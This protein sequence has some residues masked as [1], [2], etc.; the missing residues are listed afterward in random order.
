MAAAAVLL[1][2][3][4]GVGSA[5]GHLLFIAAA[6][7][8][9]YVAM[10]GRGPLQALPIA[11]LVAVLLLVELIAARAQGS[12]PFHADMT[13]VVSLILAAT[14]LVA[15]IASQ[16]FSFSV[17]AVLLLAVVAIRPWISAS[18]V[19]RVQ[20][21]AHAGHRI[22]GLVVAAVVIVAGARLL[23]LTVGQQ[24]FALACSMALVLAWLLRMPRGTAASNATA[25]G[26]GLIG[27]GVYAAAAVVR[28][29]DPFL[30]A[31]CLVAAGAFFVW[32]AAW[33]GATLEHFAAAG[34]VEAV[35]LWG[36]AQHVRW[37]E[38]Y[39]FA[40]TAYLCLVLLRHTARR[41]ENYVAAV[42]IAAAVAYPYIA[43]LRTAQR[44]HLAFLGIAG[45]VIIHVLLT[46]R[47]H[48]LMVVSVCVML[49]LGMLF[50]A[51]VLRDDVTLNLLMALVGFLVIA[52][53]GVIGSRSDRRPLVGEIGYDDNRVAR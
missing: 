16:R 33:R 28:N 8:A 39:L 40:A 1:W 50:S 27:L 47:R 48:V 32:R 29:G 5:F 26:L 49:G 21:M 44:E 23:G 13:P 14:V 30:L 9:A 6:A 18:E 34:L 31:A 17:L 19:H 2:Q 41:A 36:V 3:S 52:D 42:A 37:A 35:C 22:I 10:P 7:A 12:S 4:L 15:E 51:A 38:F 53:L 46:T 11:V 20:P 24:I 43:F 25:I 45:V